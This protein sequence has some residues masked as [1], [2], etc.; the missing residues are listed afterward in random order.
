[1]GQKS[2]TSLQQE[3]TVIITC[4]KQIKSTPTDYSFSYGVKD[5]HTG[6][7]KHQWEKKEGNS[8]KG[9]YSLVEPDGSIRTVEYTADEKNGFSAIVKKSGPLHHITTKANV[10]LSHNNVEVKHGQAYLEAEELPIEHT[11]QL[12]E[13]K[14]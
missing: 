4:K 8:I 10:A 1:M 9:Q 7:V 6:D 13:Q 14:C 2:D 3:E 12:K 5:I 11:K